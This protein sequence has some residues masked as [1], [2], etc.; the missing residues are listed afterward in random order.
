MRKHHTPRARSHLSQLR[1]RGV[2]A[3]HEGHTHSP[4]SRVFSRLRVGGRHGPRRSSTRRIQ[5]QRVGTSSREYGRAVQCARASHSLRQRAISMSSTEA[6]LMALADLAI[7]LLHLQ[8]MGEPAGLRSDQP[9][10]VY[11]DNKGPPPPS[12]G[13]DVLAH[14]GARRRAPRPRTAARRRRRHQPALL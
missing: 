12:T 1:P 7:E 4:L 5:C 11:T 3:A 14:V 10:K 13:V 8:Q 9:I 6:E 2:K